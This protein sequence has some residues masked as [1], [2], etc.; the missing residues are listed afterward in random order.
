MK[1]W[2]TTLASAVL[3]GSAAVVLTSGTSDSPEPS[4]DEA[5]VVI[6]HEHSDGSVRFAVEGRNIRGLYPGAVKQ[7]RTT[8]VNP[9]RYRLRLQKMSGKVVSTSRRGCPVTSLQVKAYSGKLPQS[10][11]PYGR[12][13]L[14][15]TLP[16]T[17]PMGTSNKCAGVHFTVALSGIGYREAR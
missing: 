2:W 7:M 13:T 4:G 10:I 3:I 9:S 6:G 8:V 5:M 1:I 16:I 17:M 15:G 11:E 14:P 12:M